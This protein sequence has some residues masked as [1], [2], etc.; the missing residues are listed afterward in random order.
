MGTLSAVIG[1][2]SLTFYLYTGNA[3]FDGLGAM[4]I[5]VSVAIL[6]VLLIVDVKDLLIGRSISPEIED[7]IRQ[8]ALA[9]KG[10]EGV[11]GLQTMYLGSEKLLI[12]LDLD[13][14]PQL[15][16]E[17]IERLIHIVKAEI[18][19]NVPTVHHIQ[20]ELASK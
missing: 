16:T 13:L 10:V 6:A 20:I 17:Q 3:Q 2:M 5:G 12:N 1:F 11:Q 7:Q 8:T 19:D 15:K 9:I 18:K 14:A 4:I